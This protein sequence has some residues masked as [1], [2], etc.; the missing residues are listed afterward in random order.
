[1]KWRR[2]PRCNS[3]RVVIR[4]NGCFG[5]VGYGVLIFGI[6]D[7]IFMLIG[8]FKTNPIGMIFASII[9]ALIVWFL[10]WAFLSLN[11]NYGTTLI[12]KDCELTFRPKND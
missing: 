5:C 1:M 12:C 10:V 2:C 4:T 11:K 3:G 9:V 6:L 8:G 7:I